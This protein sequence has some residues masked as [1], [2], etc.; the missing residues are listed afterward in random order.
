MSKQQ[1]EILMKIFNSDDSATQAVWAMGISQH[2]P[3]SSNTY[4][5]MFLIPVG[6]KIGNSRV[7]EVENQKMKIKTLKK[8]TFWLKRG[9]YLVI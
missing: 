6:M 2:W 7:L 9:L 4:S 5:N 8:I 3:T 1:K